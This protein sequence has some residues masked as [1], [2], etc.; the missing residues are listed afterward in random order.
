V[1]LCIDSDSLHGRRSIARRQKHHLIAERLH[2]PFFLVSW[3]VEVFTLSK[4]VSYG[5]C[6]C[7]QDPYFIFCN[8]F[9]IRCDALEEIDV[10]RLMRMKIILLAY[11]LLTAKFV[12]MESMIT[13]CGRP[14]QDSI[15]S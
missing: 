11:V 6:G 13:N 9:L 14:Y 7:S 4:N 8:I 10:V 5:I 3:G 2:Q 1:N 15:I 12:S